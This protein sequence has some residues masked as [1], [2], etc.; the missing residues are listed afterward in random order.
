MRLSLLRILSLLLLGV[1]PTQL[2]HA[3]PQDIPNGQAF[4]KLQNEIT[5]LN[6]DIAD[7]KSQIL[8]MRDPSAKYPYVEQVSL[9]DGTTRTLL[10]VANEWS[11]HGRDTGKYDSSG[12]PGADFG[13]GKLIN[14]L[15]EFSYNYAYYYAETESYNVK[16]PRLPPLFECPRGEVARPLTYLVQSSIHNYDGGI[17]FS[18]TTPDS[19]VYFCDQKYFEVLEGRGFGNLS[20]IRKA[21]Y[22]GYASGG[23]NPEGIRGSSFDSTY[24]FGPF[25]GDY[26]GRFVPETNGLVGTLYYEIIAPDGCIV[27][28]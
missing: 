2:S 6:A 20:C 7:L 8:D 5:S 12:D 19:G 21:Y 14:A 1:L 18:N 10:Y 27:K 3:G 24:S 9:G 25:P 28:K 26:A 13:G 23:F 22:R 15:G 4:K 16:I 17:L 11:N